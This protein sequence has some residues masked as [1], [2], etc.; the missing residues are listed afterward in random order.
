MKKHY[1]IALG[2]VVICGC[3]ALG[4][5]ALAPPPPGVTKENFDR[6]QI[7]MKKKDVEAI[8]GGE[9]TVSELHGT[10]F[11]RWSTLEW[12]GKDQ[13]KAFLEFHDDRVSD[14]SWTDSPPTF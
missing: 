7:G 2:L 10:Q 4:I 12:T 3:A 1:L 8:F 13:S 9:G 6:V 14:K 5:P 11:R